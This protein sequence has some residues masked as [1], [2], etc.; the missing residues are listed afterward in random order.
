MDGTRF[1][2]L[3][4]RLAA[5]FSRRRGL[6]FLTVLGSGALLT[7]GGAEAKKHKKKPCPACRKR[8]KG[9]CK[10]I[11]PDNT[12]CDGGVCVG[13]QCL[14]CPAGQRLCQGTCIANAT[15]CD[16]SDCPL[17]GNGRKQVCTDG[18]CACV[19]D[20]EAPPGGCAGIAFCCSNDCVTGLCGT[21]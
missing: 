2:D 10:G 17:N 13:G 5:G 15:C 20:F 7:Q 6:G 19:P 12:A 1:D 18:T 9:K 3:T 21:P 14:P 11:L 8:K 16:N 4:T